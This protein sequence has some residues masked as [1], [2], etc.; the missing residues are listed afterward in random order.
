MAVRDSGADGS[1]QAMRCGGCGAKVASPILRRVLERLGQGE[2]GRVVAGLD[3][4]DDAAIIRPPAGKVLVQTVDQFRAF[5]D[6]PYPFGRITVNHC[7]GD[8][9]AMGAKPLSALVSLA[10][11]AAPKP[12]WKSMTV[13]LVWTLGAISLT[14]VCSDFSFSSLRPIRKRLWPRRASSR[15]IALP[16]PSVHP[17]ITTHEPYVAFRSM[18]LRSFVT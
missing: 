11:S 8:I 2:H 10:P 18:L 17:V 3:A 14:S 5:I 12:F 6:D 16:I 7:L 9:Y 1:D 15:A 13:N 4:S